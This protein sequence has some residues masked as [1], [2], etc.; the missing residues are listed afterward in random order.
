MIRVAILDPQPAMRAGLEAIL[1]AAP[2]VVP[3]GG[4]ADRRALWPLLYRADPDVV[5]VP[6]A[7]TCLAVRGRHPRSRVVIYATDADVVLAACA[8]A[9]ALV[10]RA[11]P[12][13][14]LL[15]ALRGELPLAITPRRQRRAAAKL[16]GIERAILAMRL[17]G[18]PD[19]EIAATVGMPRDALAGRIAAIV[20]GTVCSLDGA[21]ELYAG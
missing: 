5:L 6:D 19:A 8:G 12:P 1:R 3:V 14:E 7:P 2:G 15:A 10:S 20:S 4:V 16:G 13:Q 21:G 17:A 11:S 18:T 9:M